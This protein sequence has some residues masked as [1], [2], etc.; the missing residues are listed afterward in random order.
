MKLTATTFVSVDGVMQGIGGQDEDQRGGFE[1]G[2]WAVPYFDHENITPLE[3]TYQRADGSSTRCAT[4][5]E[6]APRTGG[7][8]M[9]QAS[10]VIQETP[11]DAVRLHPRNLRRQVGDLAEMAQ[12]MKERGVS[13]DRHRQAPQQAGPLFRHLGA[14]RRRHAHLR[15]HRGRG[16]SRLDYGGTGEITGEPGRFPRGPLPAQRGGWQLRGRA[17]Q[18]G[19]GDPPLPRFVGI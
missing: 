7:I 1:R 6:G 3:Q 2:G 14:A 10:L 8:V 16:D 4:W 12:S 19:R 17:I 15:R 11:L 13:P 5:T 9:S 18:T